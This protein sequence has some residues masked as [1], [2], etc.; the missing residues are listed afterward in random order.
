VQVIQK[1]SKTSRELFNG[2]AQVLVRVK[3]GEAVRLTAE[4]EGLKK[5]EI[6]IN[7]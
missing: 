4:S 7:E 5:T 3:G 6:V 1:S 2:Y